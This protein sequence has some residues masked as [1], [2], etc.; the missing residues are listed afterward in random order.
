MGTLRCACGALLF[1]GVV[2]KGVSVTQFGNGKFNAKC[3]HCKR[4]NEGINIK[5]LTGELDEDIDFCTR[6]T[7]LR[8]SKEPQFSH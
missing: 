2:Y 1:D 3:R 8:Q 7:E 4:F 6:N 5:L